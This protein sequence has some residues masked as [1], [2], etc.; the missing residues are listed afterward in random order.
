MKWIPVPGYVGIYEISEQGN[1]RS[2][3]RSV[4]CS[5]GEIR[6]YRG[7]TL[8]I[9]M[10]KKGYATVSLNYMNERKLFFVHRLLAMAFIPN[11]NGKPHINHKDGNCR[12]NSL[13]NLE[14]CTHRE[15]ME[16][17]AANLLTSVGSKHGMSILDESD[18]PEIRSRYEKGE[19]PSSIASSFG[20]SKGAIGHIVKRTSWRHVQ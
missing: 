16:H 3:D 20:V 9:T 15:N 13:D 11:P 18:I 12:N 19:K 17:A 8:T 14:W 7:K 5:S 6:K 10:D 1:L 4:H 2:V